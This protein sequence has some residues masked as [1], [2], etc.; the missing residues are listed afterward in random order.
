MKWVLDP[1]TVTFVSNGGSSVVNQTV[2][3]GSKITKPSDPVLRYH[4]FR[5]WFL[6]NGH[7]TE[8]WNFYEIPKE[9]LTLY[10]KWEFEDGDH[11]LD[12]DGSP[13]NPYKVYNQ[14]TLEKVG[15]E[16][17]PGTW[18]LWAYYEQITNIYYDINEST[19]VSGEWE[20]IGRSDRSFT[21]TYEGNG[22]YIEGLRISAAPSTNQYRGLFGYIANEGVVR[23]LGLENAGIMIS[24]D[25]VVSFIGSLAGKI[26]YNAEV[27]NCYV[28]ESHIK[29]ETD[30][31]GLYI[32]GLVGSN[33]GS[34]KNCFVYE[35]LVEGDQYVGGI[36]GINEGGT[37]ENCYATGAVIGNAYAGGIS[38]QSQTSISGC[39]ALNYEIVIMG[40][41][42]EIG[43][44]TSNS[45][46]DI[47]D[48]FAYK[49]MILGI[50][51]GTTYVTG[52]TTDINGG[53]IIL[54]EIKNDT[55]WKKAGF[56]FGNTIERPWIW[57]GSSMPSL[58]G[59][60]TTFEWQ[61][62]LE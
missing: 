61:D 48:N 26:D 46:G 37:I 41:D 1:R 4:Y 12:T 7:F 23:N 5:G 27:Y 51:K 54:S 32:G 6:D 58:K 47:N 40:N 2:L 18:S 17:G 45:I 52:S 59:F 15:T 53:D 38:G 28:S 42:S 43:R 14:A 29:C 44:I 20:P 50:N 24:N 49:N 11:N 60:S 10:A 55:V 57:K 16:T 31:N 19:T 9:N 13:D 3:K 8:Q 39:I 34:I 56:S 25:S 21:G 35:I 30:L 36:T 22:Y 62:Y 33:D